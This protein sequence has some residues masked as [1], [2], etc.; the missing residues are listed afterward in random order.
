MNQ[1]RQSALT[2]MDLLHFGQTMGILNSTY[3]LTHPDHYNES[4]VNFVR[5]LNFTE[6][7]LNDTGRNFIFTLVS[8][9]I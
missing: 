6:L 5:G 9:E 1:F 2:A 3:Q 8:L 4:F 7:A